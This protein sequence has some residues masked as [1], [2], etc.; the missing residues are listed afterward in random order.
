[1]AAD[2]GVYFSSNKLPSLEQWERAA[3]ELGVRLRIMP[4]D[5][6]SH[7]GM[8]PIAFGVNDYNTGFEFELTSDWGRL[9]ELGELLRT[10]DM[11][12]YFRCFSREWPAAVWAAVSFA[13]ASDGVFQDPMGTTFAT[14]DEALAYARAE[15]QPKSEAY[16]AE[17][18]AK[19]KA[20]LDELE[21]AFREAERAN[22]RRV[23]QG[24]ACPKCGFSYAWNGSECGHC[25]FR[26]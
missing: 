8:L 10:R 26:K 15:S 20:S 22:Q 16:E 2:F 14:F 17:R 13:K 1:M 9:E 21:A 23:E 12:A 25:R 19:I 24:K 18:M 6:R 3:A 7:S 11:F 5:L 4:V